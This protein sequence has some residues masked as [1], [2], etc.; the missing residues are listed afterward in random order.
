MALTKVLTGGLAADSVDNTIL[1]LDDNYALTGTVTGSGG[2]ELLQT[3]TAGSDVGNITFTS[4]VLTS[5]YSTYF[6]TGKIIGTGDFY[7]HA[8][9]DNGS[10]YNLTTASAGE[11][12]YN[13][14][15]G[16]NEGV[17][18]TP[19][20]IEG[21]NSRIT[22]IGDIVSGSDSF[23]TGMMMF[24]G[25]VCNS[26]N[27]SVSRTSCYFGMSN[28]MYGQ[29]DNYHTMPSYVGGTTFLNA[30]AWNNLKFQW[31]SGNIIATSTISL[32]GVK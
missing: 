13:N 10:N 11:G 5:T 32:Y 12:S 9:I 21:T 4:S 8:S 14:T 31:S 17:Y 6:V 29:S 18:A 7:L 1:K 22:I 27:Y 20:R 3:Q 19:F 16:N 23:M 25:Y 26:T 28:R 15:A 30:S 24:S 2:M